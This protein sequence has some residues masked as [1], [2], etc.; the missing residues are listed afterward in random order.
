MLV[1]FVFVANLNIMMCSILL[2][3]GT[4]T[5]NTITEEQFMEMGELSEGYSGSDISVVVREAIMEPL[6]KCQSA[7]QFMLTQEGMYTPCE[8][9]PNCPYCPPKLA[10]QTV[11]S[12]GV[13][14][15]QCQRCGAIRMSLYDIETDK[16]QVPVVI[17][18]D[19]EKA[20][21]KAHSSVGQDELQQFVKWTEEF[22]QEG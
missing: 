3:S 12:G 21:T 15:P 8:E 5:P 1:H 10:T 19:F 2:L 6:R 7:Q 4:D 14:S 18:S 11:F 22:G 13:Q 9:Y 17:Y 20:L 16:L